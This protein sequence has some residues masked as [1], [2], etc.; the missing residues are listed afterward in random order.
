MRQVLVRADSS[1]RL[2]PRQSGQGVPIRHPN[3]DTDAGGA[4]GRLDGVAQAT[5]ALVRAAGSR[6]DA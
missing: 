1:P 3:P 6:P 2:E 4:M 5:P